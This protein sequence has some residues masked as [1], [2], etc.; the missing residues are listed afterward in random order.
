[1]PGGG[2]VRVLSLGRCAGKW[3]GGVGGKM[4]VAS[5]RAGRRE[6]GTGLRLGK[7]GPKEQGKSL[8]LHRL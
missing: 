6:E 5:V 2:P 7:W 4:L 1:M 8:L 3:E